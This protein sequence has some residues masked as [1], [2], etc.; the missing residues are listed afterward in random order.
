VK[1]QGT[2]IKSVIKNSFWKQAKVQ[3][4]HP[5]AQSLN[6]LCTCHENPSARG[7]YMLRKFVCVGF[8]SSQGYGAAIMRNCYENTLPPAARGPHGMGDLLRP[9]AI[10]KASLNEPNRQKMQQNADN[11][12]MH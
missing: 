6:L 7:A 2:G 9:S 4:I 3:E 11:H 12:I 10:E 5:P 1:I 8:H